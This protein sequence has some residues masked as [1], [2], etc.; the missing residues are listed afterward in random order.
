MSDKPLTDVCFENFSLDPQLLKGLEDAGFIR[1]TPIQAVS[2][3]I[4][5]QG[6]DVAGQAQTGTGK[7]AAFLV[8]MFNRLLT[9]PARADRKDNEPR[10]VILAPTRE[11]AIQI[12]KDAQQIGRNLG[13]RMAL[14]YGG[15]DYDKQRTQLS[16]GVDVII[17]T[18]GR[19]IDFVRQHAV[20]LRAVDVVILDEA[21][22]MFDLG[23]IKDIRFLLRR[24]PA[25]HQRQNLR[26]SA[27]LSPRVPDL[28]ITDMYMPECD[29][30]EMITLLR[31]K[32]ADVPIIAMSAGQLQGVDV[33][34]MAGR[35]GAQVQLSKPFNETQLLAA[36]DQAFAAAGPGT[37]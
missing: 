14:I 34:G 8:S 5:R 33:L 17:A 19:L 20:S 7:T 31:A 1:C 11:L 24:M 23:F 9:K 15:V 2:L 12:E 16:D 36:V 30:L 27:T 26:F 22:R 29:G 21:D 4:T 18:P 25:P 35:L 3:P 37:S 32:R 28:F 10:A 6:G 13:L